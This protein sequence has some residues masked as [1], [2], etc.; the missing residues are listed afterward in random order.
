M[1][2]SLRRLL[3]SILATVVKDLDRPVILVGG[4]GC[5]GKTIFSE[6]IA[7]HLRSSLK[8]SVSVLDLDCYL[9]EREVRESRTQKISGYNPKGYE[10]STTVSDIKSILNGETICVSLYDKVTSRRT[11]NMKIA[12]AEILIVEGVM[13]LTDSIREFGN[14]RIFLDAET[15]VQFGNR[16]AREKKLGFDEDRIKTKFAHLMEDYDRFIVPQRNF[17]DFIVNVDTDYEFLKIE[18]R[19]SFSRS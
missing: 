7:T 3:L 19:S 16:L 11:K 14:V 18:I 5:V 15:R 10:L 9:I 6:E 8:S 17:A 4:T 2:M 1:S 12:P 13:A